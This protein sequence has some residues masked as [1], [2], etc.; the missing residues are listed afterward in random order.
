MRDSTKVYKHFMLYVS[1]NIRNDKIGY[2]NVPKVVD[3]S[4][5]AQH[6]VMEVASGWVGGGWGGSAAYF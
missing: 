1:V 3:F 2:R 4:S 6:V 5:F